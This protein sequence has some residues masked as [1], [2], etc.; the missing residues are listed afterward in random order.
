M[1]EQGHVFLFGVGYTGIKIATVFHKMGYKVSGTVQTSD[2]LNTLT[3]LSLFTHLFLYSNKKEIECEKDPLLEHLLVNE[4]TH[5]ISTIAPLREESGIECS[6]FDPVLSLYLTAIQEASQCNFIG[7]L[8]SIGVYGEYGDEIINENFPLKTQIA[9]GKRRV[10][11]EADWQSIGGTIFRLPGIYGPRRGPLAKIRSGHVR[12]IDLPNRIFHSIHVD[13]IASSVFMTA[14]MLKTSEVYNITDDAPVIAAIRI[15]HAAKLMKIEAPVRQKWED[16]VGDMSEFAKSFYAEGKRVGNTKMHD[17]LNITLRY[18]SYITGL[19][20]QLEEED[21]LQ[22]PKLDPT[23][24]VIVVNTGSLRPAPYLDLRYIAA[25]LASHWKMNATV[26]ILT[27][28]ARHSDT[29]DDSTLFHQKAKTFAQILADLQLNSPSITTVSVLPLFFGPSKTLTEFLPT[30]AYEVAPAL[31]VTF[32]LP[33]ITPNDNRIAQILHEGIVGL[34]K[35]QL[36]PDEVYQVLVVDHGTPTPSVHETRTIIGEQLSSLLNEN[37]QTASME[38]PKSEIEGL[39]KPLL[40]NALEDFAKRDCVVIVALL[41]FAQGR[42]AGAGGDIESIIQ[43]VQEKHPTLR[44][45]VT[46]TLQH[47]RL[48]S[49]I[50]IDRYTTLRHEK[51]QRVH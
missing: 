30:Q 35:E 28:S 46:P 50:L 14:H 16:V 42:H 7:Y 33:L 36:L 22:I 29:I 38:N 47:H 10:S 11:A 24:A 18:P 21:D 26:C 13:D 1:H 12:N 5:I 6:E 9:R 15:E 43:N 32:A 19:A 23:H 20:A 39:N 34:A 27:A 2:H 8:S 4:I 40:E 51:D 37:V 49:E 45:L 3:A 44:V 17:D 31:D 48:L 25:Q 41:F